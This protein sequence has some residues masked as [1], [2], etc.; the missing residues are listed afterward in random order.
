[1]LLH[2]GT[3]TYTTTL[4]TPLPA[5]AQ[6]KLTIAKQLP[7]QIGWIY[8]FSIHCDTV[9]PDNDPLISTSE[10]QNLYMTLK[11]GATDFYEDVRLDD[12]L[13]V[14]GGTPNQRPLNYLPASI[15]GDFDLST[16]Y[17]KNPTGIVTPPPAPGV[18]TLTIA[19]QIWYISMVTYNTLIANGALGSMGLLNKPGVAPVVP[20]FSRP[21]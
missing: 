7:T 14:Y 5:V 6:T 4:Y 12:M 20:P 13:T 10:A 3:P 8:G 18:G 16:S 19:L 17:Y 11:H 9:T 21:K 2:W 1:M 15:P